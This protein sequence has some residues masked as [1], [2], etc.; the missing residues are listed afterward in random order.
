MAG[1]VKCKDAVL[2]IELIYLV[3]PIGTVDAPSMNKN[4]CFVSLAGQTIMEGRRDFKFFLALFWTVAGREKGEAN[5]R[6]CAENAL[7]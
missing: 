5:Y 4:Q 6:N 1:Q 7:S 3:V 2:R